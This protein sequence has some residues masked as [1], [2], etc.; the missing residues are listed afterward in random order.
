MKNVSSAG[1]M[2]RMQIFAKTI[3]IM[4]QYF[5]FGSGLGSYA[6]VYKLYED[7]QVVTNVFSPH[8]HNDYLEMVLE[9]GFVGIL[10]IT[11]FIIWW[12]R[13]FFTLIRKRRRYG[14]VG[15]AASIAVLAVLLH[16]IVDY[17]MRTIAISTLFAFC[18]SLISTN[19][20]RQ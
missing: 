18:L 6:D 10:L 14:V 11:A 8:T 3:E 15:I 12:G 1:D 4:P 16:S 5:P 19:L 13:S 7:K 9:Y 17:P 20:K 2:S